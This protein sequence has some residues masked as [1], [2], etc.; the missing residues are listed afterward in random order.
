[1][2]WPCST[3]LSCIFCLRQSPVAPS[4]GSR[5]SG[6]PV[7][8]A[9]SREVAG[10]VVTERGYGVPGEDRMIY[11]AYAHHLWVLRATRGAATGNIPLGEFLAR[12]S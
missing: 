10:V 4:S 11:F 12:A 6:S 3:S 7:L 5:S 9:D 2:S 8:R 1:M